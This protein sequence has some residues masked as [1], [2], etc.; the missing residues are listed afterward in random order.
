MRQRPADATTAPPEEVNT[1]YLL[2]HELARLRYQ[3]AAALAER[4][5]ARQRDALRS[6]R[7]ERRTWLRSLWSR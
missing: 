2:A 7:G 4:A 1:M 5:E 6:N 3:E